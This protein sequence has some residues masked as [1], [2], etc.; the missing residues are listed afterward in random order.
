MKRL[1]F[2]LFAYAGIY[3][4]LISA[5]MEAVE[6]HD[7]RKNPTIDV[8]K[9]IDFE[10]FGWGEHFTV[11][12]FTFLLVNYFASYFVGLILSDKRKINYGLLFSLSCI[13]LQA[14]FYYQSSSSVRDMTSFS[15]GAFN[16]NEF[17]IATWVAVV[18]HLF[19]GTYGYI[20]GVENELRLNEDG[21]ILKLNWT[22]WM[23]IV[24]PIPLNPIFLIE[25]DIFTALLFNFDLIREVKHFGPLFLPLQLIPIFVS[26][27]FLYKLFNFLTVENESSWLV[28]FS[29]GLFIS[30]SGVL[31]GG[32]SISLIYALL[33][34]INSFL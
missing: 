26:S 10:F 14:Y 4:S 1:F 18:S 11:F 27:Y 2:A 25:I 17:P 9:K 6:W 16:N 24:L 29:K 5:M 21:S 23:W 33:F 34:W 32:V 30:F 28:N 3:M 31:C 7:K 13:T 12:V 20:H 22:H 19:T 15:V 8:L